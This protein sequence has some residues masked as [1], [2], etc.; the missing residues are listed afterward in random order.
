MKTTLHEILPGVF[1][2]VV[3]TARFKT[4]CF[5]AAFL[6]P[7][8]GESASMGALIPHVLRRGTRDLPDMECLNAAMDDLYGARIEPTVRKKGDIQVSGLI[9]DLV[10]INGEPRL[11]HDTLAL[12][13]AILLNPVTESGAFL[14]EYVSGE[15]ENLKNAILSESN[16]KLHYAVRRATREFY[17]DSGFGAHELGD[18]DSTADITPEKLYKYYKKVFLKAPLELFFCGNASFDDVKNAILPTLKTLQRDD[19]PKIGLGVPSCPQGHETIECMDTQQANIIIGH[20]TDIRA[21]SDSMPAMMVLATLLGGG[22]ASKLFVNVRERKSLCYYTG[23]VYNEFMQTVFLYAGVDPDNITSARGEMLR[24]LSA[25]IKSEISD[26]ELL[27]AKK[28]IIDS[29]KTTCDSAIALEGYWLNRAIADDEYS[30]NDMNEM[31]ESVTTDD[32]VRAAETLIN[33]LTYVLS[34][35]E[36][37]HARKTLPGNR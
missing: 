20:Y 9:C 8:T 6:M 18:V 17:G 33:C 22:T 15:C 32:A 7:L 29:L 3:E 4:A 5:R 26:G 21:G 25:C 16:D 2:R 19:I 10:S 31:I 36:E 11:M 34:G 35:E 14:S 1:L 27:F 23:A 12:A 28:R 13:L 30:P 24:Q 37:Q